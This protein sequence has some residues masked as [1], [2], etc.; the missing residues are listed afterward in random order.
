M[1]GN[2]RWVLLVAV[3]LFLSMGRPAAAITDAVKLDSSTQFLSGDDQLGEG[4]AVLAQYLR[5]NIKPENRDILIT[6]YGRVWKDFSS[7]GVRDDDLLGRL[8]YLYVDYRA[9][10]RLSLRLGRQFVNFSAGSSIL[11]GASVELEGI[12]P[13]GVT[14]AGGSDVRYLLDSEESDFDDSV[15][16]VDIHLSGF[17][18]TQLGLSYV[19]RF[20]EWDRA[21]EEFG[22]SFRRYFK[23]L[24]PYAE[25]RYDR[26]SEAVDE[27]TLGLDVFPTTDLMLKGEFYHS[28]PTFDST[29]IYSVFAV[30]KYREYLIRAEYSIS[31]PVTVFASY[32][33]QT[34]EDD[35]DAD[36]YEV[37]ARFRPMQR[38]T[39]NASVDYREGFGGKDW[40]FEAYGDYR[41]GEKFLVSAGAQHDTY[42]RPED[43]GDQYAQR[44]WVGGQWH[45]SKDASLL[46]RV[47]DNVNE[48]FNHRPLGRV[49]LNW[50]L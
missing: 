17:R 25:V 22:L 19:M 39:I 48:N 35:D 32:A 33:R 9:S 30:D 5:L 1:S 6:G 10:D 3:V 16:G 14:L 40:G 23:Y 37:G 45:I 31:A 20:D 13:I 24:S 4:Q 44:Y 34:Y 11:D 21:R 2:C 50:N 43:T 38:M 27:A 26:L 47:E 36:R 28:Y 15:F 46:A 18:S 49:A 29:S 41:I 42:K 7:G 8:Y 12:G